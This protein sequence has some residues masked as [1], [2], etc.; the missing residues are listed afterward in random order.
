LIKIKAQ[1]AKT[2]PNGKISGPGA[3]LPGKAVAQVST[4]EARPQKFQKAISGP[5][6]CDTAAM[7]NPRACGHVV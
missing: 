2:A 1:S 4:R 7:V 3:E 6:H 5:V